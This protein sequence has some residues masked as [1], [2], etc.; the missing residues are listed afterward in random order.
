MK[1]ND[2]EED[3][4]ATKHKLERPPGEANRNN[5]SSKIERFKLAASTGIA[6]V[7][8]ATVA[9]PASAFIFTMLPSAISYVIPRVFERKTRLAA[10]W[11]EEVTFANASEEGV[12]ADIKAHLDEPAAQET[13]MAGFRNVMDSISVEVIP[14]LALLT[15]EYLRTG[16]TA[17]RFFR[18]LGR[19]LVDLSAEE[20]ETLRILMGQLATIEEDY[21]LT[22]TIHRPDEKARDPEWAAGLISISGGLTDKGWAVN[23]RIPLLPHASHIFKELKAQGIAHDYSSGSISTGPLGML[24]AREVAARIAPLLPD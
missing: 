17:D 8:A 3:D 2:K 10:A 4:N 13:I 21:V 6:A 18:A 23:R 12:A 14:A 15:R 24:I 9:D 22:V 20:Y 16:R 7:K 1:K 11:W 5:K 19:L